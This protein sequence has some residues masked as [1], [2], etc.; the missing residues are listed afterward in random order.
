MDGFLKTGFQDLVQKLGDAVVISTIDVYQAIVETKLPTPARFHYL[1][2]LRDISKVIQGILMTRPI[3][4]RDPE[5]LGKLWVH[6]VQ[7]VFHDRLI[8]DEDRDWFNNLL[9]D[10]LAKNFRLNWDYEEVFKRNVIYFGDLLKLEAP[11][12]LYEPITDKT[13][14]K[15]VL[16]T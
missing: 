5:T 2:N 14:L 12:Q 1:F 7:R 10:Q 6:E 9:I 8:D 4:I 3:S 13:K 15:K 11:E 16:E